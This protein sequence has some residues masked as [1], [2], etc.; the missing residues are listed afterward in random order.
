MSE[1]N[2]P[3]Q[4]SITGY[5]P[6]GYAVSI[7]FELP[8]IPT[9]WDAYDQRMTAL[10]LS[11]RQSTR[12]TKTETISHVARRDH[13]NKSGTTTPHIAFYSASQHLE[14]RYLHVY[15][16]TAAERRAFEEATGIS[17]DTIPVQDADTHP[18]RDG[19]PRS[20]TY[21]LPLPR[22]ITIEYEEETF[23]GEDGSEGTRK[24]LTRYIP[25]NNSPSRLGGEVAPPVGTSNATPDNHDNT[26]KDSP[27]AET[28]NSA[29]KPVRASYSTPATPAENN[30][31]SPME[32][33]TGGEVNSRILISPF[34]EP[35]ATDGAR[36]TKP[37][38]DDQ[39]GKITRISV[40]GKDLAIGDCIIMTEMTY[41]NPRNQS[42]A[43][44]T[45]IETP[46]P[47]G[48]IKAS[49]KVNGDY[50]QK[51]KFREFGYYTVVGG[52]KLNAAADD[53]ASY[54]MHPELGATWTMGTS[55][56]Q[57]AV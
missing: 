42:I 25:H 4:F 43:T 15:M 50:E 23:I 40:L 41:D 28:T 16:D 7:S 26:E 11:P 19:S 39:R 30:S 55:V 47:R 57:F 13:Y 54:E 53:P 12:I 14:M 9:T 24:T 3:K 51:T 10:G 2:Q 37:K 20:K 17:I 1:Q 44:I 22:P 5:T 31:P 56:S 35:P 49:F 6:A 32:R 48:D 18:K 36:G 38:R 33:G 29:D 8:A 45:A 46:D 27:P 34:A 21:I 52:S